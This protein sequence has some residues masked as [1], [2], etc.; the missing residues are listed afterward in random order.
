VKDADVITTVHETKPYV[1][2]IKPQGRKNYEYIDCGKGPDQ[3]TCKRNRLLL[4]F[5]L[6]VSLSLLIVCMQCYS[7]DITPNRLTPPP[8]PTPPHYSPSPIGYQC[9]Q[10]A[11]KLHEAMFSRNQERIKYANLL[12]IE[13]SV[14]LSQKVVGRA[15]RKLC[16]KVCYPSYTYCTVLYCA[17][18]YCTVLYCTILYCTILYCT[19]LYCTVLCCTV[20]CCTVLYYTVLY[21]TVLYCTVLYCTVLYYTILYYTVLC[22]TVLYYTIL[23]CNVLYCT[24]LYCTILYCTILYCAVLYCTILYYT[25]L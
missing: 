18:L 24:V 11:A 22:C 9:L 16:L 5:A 10:R 20:L 6:H 15:Y 7:Q 2:R 3:T 19:V 4:L 17:V 21:Y 23:Y 12:G 13:P 1:I 14:K 8:Y 25:V